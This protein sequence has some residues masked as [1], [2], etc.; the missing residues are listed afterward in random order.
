LTKRQL[1]III[2]IKYLAMKQC[3]TVT[4]ILLLI[5][6]SEIFAQEFN[7]ALD[8]FNHEFLRRK[9]AGELDPSIEGSPFIVDDFQEAVIYMKGS[10]PVKQASALI[11]TT[12]FFKYKKVIR[13]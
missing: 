2:Y 10:E 1:C 6:T 5:S 8:N 7:Q 4:I 13:F 11:P 3:F 12:I 9:V